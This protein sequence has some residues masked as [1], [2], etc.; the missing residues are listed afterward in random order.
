MKPF[1][2]HPRRFLVLILAII[3]V[4]IISTVS[5]LHSS[6]GREGYRYVRAQGD[7]I[8]VAIHY[9]PM[10]LYRYGDSLGGLNYEIA[11]QI[12][13]QY[14]DKFKFYP[15]SSST[16]ALSGL[17]EGKYDIVIADI[18][19]TS[20]LKE[21]YLFTD[22]IYTDQQVLVGRDSTISSPLHLAGQKV[23]VVKGSP[24]V[25]R[26][27]NL[28][29]EIGDTIC[30]EATD[31]YTAEQLVLL[32]A[33]GEIDRAVVNEDVAS[34]I[35]P[36]YPQLIISTGISFTQFQSWILNRDEKDLTKKLNSQIAQFKTTEL[37]DSLIRKWT[38]AE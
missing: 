2:G 29:R 24:A 21:K 19:V 9:S 15:I 17:A 32:T 18:P 16:Q 4:G 5:Y 27:E 33:G 30:I 38:I 11:T 8:N 6:S 3:A 22:P 25:E 20:S 36:S 13:R 12:S 37:Y 35:A 14:G 34:R 26:L 23:W 7:S 31:R 10:S 28:E 1:F